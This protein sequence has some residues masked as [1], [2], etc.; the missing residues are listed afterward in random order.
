MISP[1]SPGGG[2]RP[3]GEWH[4]VCLVVMG[5]N[6]LDAFGQQIAG[7]RMADVAQTEDADHPL[8]LVDHRQPA[9]SV[10][11]REV[12]AVS[13]WTEVVACLH[14]TPAGFTTPTFDGRGLRDPLLARPAG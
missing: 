1:H 6:A 5:R 8:A 4:H 11:P 14:R 13:F 10:L 2:L 9:Q 3:P 7:R 12:C